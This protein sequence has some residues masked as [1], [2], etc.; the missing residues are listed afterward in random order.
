M[1]D[2]AAPTSQPCMP[3]RQCQYRD[4]EGEASPS[5][6]LDVGGVA[7]KCQ[8]KQAEVSRLFLRGIQ[9]REPEPELFLFMLVYEYYTYL[10]CI[11]R[12]RSRCIHTY[13][14]VCIKVY[15]CTYIYICMCTGLCD[16]H[17][18]KSVYTEVFMLYP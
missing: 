18:V 12:S 1:T 7:R 8:L 13:I 2:V 6:S 4:L 16:F 10:Y 3:D 15:I 11:R 9:V 5:Q 17:Y 14:H